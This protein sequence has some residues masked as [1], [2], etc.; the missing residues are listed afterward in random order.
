LLTRKAPDLEVTRRRHALSDRRGQNANAELTSAGPE[1][2][3][4]G[5]ALR[6]REQLFGGAGLIDRPPANGR[7]EDSDDPVAIARGAELCLERA[8]LDVTA[9]KIRRRRAVR[10]LLLRRN[11]VAAKR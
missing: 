7:C 1:F 8:G 9:P 5:A 6:I 3:V 4:F 10:A 11:V 2:R